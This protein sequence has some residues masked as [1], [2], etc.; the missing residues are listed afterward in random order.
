MLCCGSN[1]YGQLGLGKKCERTLGVEDLKY[2]IRE[3]FVDVDG[4][5]QKFTATQFA[6]M[7]IDHVSSKFTST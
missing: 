2:Y 1:L 4:S 7:Y 5:D 6:D 3:H